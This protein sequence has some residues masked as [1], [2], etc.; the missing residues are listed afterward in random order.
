MLFS[1]LHSI[2]TDA[3]DLHDIQILIGVWSTKEWYE[4]VVRDKTRLVQHSLETGQVLFSKES[5]S[6]IGNIT[7]V[8]LAGVPCVAVSYK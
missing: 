3:E 6:P 7:H 2:H 5:G 8:K 4:C 1:V